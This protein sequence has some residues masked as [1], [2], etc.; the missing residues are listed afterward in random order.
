MDIRLTWYGH[1]TVLVEDT[2][3]LLTDPVLTRA[4]LHL[5]RRAG[6]APGRQLRPIDAVL[7]SHLH[8]D[9]LH[10]PSLALLPSGTRVLVP[11]GARHL[12][13]HLSVVPLEVEAGDVVQVGEAVVEVVPA[14]HAAHRWPWRGASAAAVG[15][16]VRG[17][18]STYFAGDTT[19]FPAMAGIDPA[20]D[21]ALLPVG[22]WG[23]WLRGGHLTP[24]SAAECLPVLGPRVTVPIHYGTLWP[25]GL[26]G[27]RPRAFHEPGREFEAR[28]LHVAPSV[29]VR[30]IPPGSSTAV[31]LPLGQPGRRPHS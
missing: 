2:A 29:E 31:C 24:T 30:V 12:L 10:L 27:V 8:A 25:R 9:H 4:L 28:A 11:R 19:A 14:V 13:R 20:L 16:V 18:G 15:Y 26:S 23:P 7:I 1:A 3:R 17:R 21:V 6:M 22:G 5:R